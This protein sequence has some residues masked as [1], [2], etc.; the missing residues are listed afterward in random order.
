MMSN[1]LIYV[2]IQGQYKFVLKVTDADGKSDEDDVKVYVKPPTN[3]PPVAVAGPDK[4]LSLPLPF[5]T[6]H[7]SKSHDDGNITSFAWSLQTAPAG[8]GAKV[9]V[10]LAP[11]AAVTNVTGLGVGSYTFQ[12]S[13]EDNSGNTHSDTVQVVVKQDTNTP[14]VA[15]PGRNVK[16]SLPVTEVKLK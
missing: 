10:I 12:L 1:N 2:S 11:E 3:L 5:L 6:L 13:V 15:V 4:E 8:A 16:I 9:P 14:P 7:G